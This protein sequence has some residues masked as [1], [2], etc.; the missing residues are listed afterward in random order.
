MT[1][2]RGRRRKEEL[3]MSKNKSIGP[4]GELCHRG[5]I[6]I[7]LNPACAGLPVTLCISHR[8]VQENRSKYENRRGV[9]VSYHRGDMV[10]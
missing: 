7:E 6:P 9:Q 1:E 8:M 2:R 10:V 5:N 3:D 4:V